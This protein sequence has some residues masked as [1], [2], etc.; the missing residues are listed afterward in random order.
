M[1]RIPESVLKE[2]FPKKL[3]RNTGAL[4]TSKKIYDDLKKK[5][6]SGKLKKGRKLTE[7]RLAEKYNVSRGTARLAVRKLKKEGLLFCKGLLGTFV[8]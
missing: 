6:L 4:W 3:K 7:M 1:S 2:I 8:K 5:I